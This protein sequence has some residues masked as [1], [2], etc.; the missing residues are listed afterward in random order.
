MIELLLAEVLRFGGKLKVLYFPVH[1]WAA[2]DDDVTGCGFFFIGNC[3]IR[4]QP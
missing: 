3:E 4:R 2:L 1:E